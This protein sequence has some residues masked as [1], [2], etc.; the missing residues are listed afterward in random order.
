MLYYNAMEA[1][2]FEKVN[3]QYSEESGAVLRNV[4]FSVDA[5]E[6]VCMLGRNGSGKST[7]AR[8]INGLLLPASGKVTVFGMDTADKAQ[9]FNVRKRVGIVFQNPDNQ[10]VAAIVE[11]DVAFGPENLGLSREE[12]GKRIDFALDG[13]NMRKYRY[14]MADKLS[15]GQKQRVAVAGMLA[16]RPDVLILDESTSMLDAR[17]RKEVLGVVKKLNDEGMTVISVTHYMDEAADADR[18]IVLSDGEIVEDGLPDEIFGNAEDLRRY[19]LELPRAAYIAENL[20]KR[21]VPLKSGILT[22]DVLSEELCKSLLK[23]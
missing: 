22:E 23:I 19:G 5:G 9:T 12:I 11:D 20:R 21:G 14:E 16:M 17:G 3:F 15:G 18:I 10:Q 2:R 7:V 8:L 1:I 4:S 13:A 6:Y